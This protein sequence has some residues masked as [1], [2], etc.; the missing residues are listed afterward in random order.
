MSRGVTGRGGLEGVFESPHVKRIFTSDRALHD[1]L[2]SLPCYARA[3]LPVLILGEPGTGKE[4][5][6]EALWALSPR[7]EQPFVRL[8][9]ANLGGNLAGSELFGHLKGAFTG[10]ERGRAGKFK[11]AHRGTLFLDEVGDLPLSVQPRLLRVLERGEIEPLGSDS[12]LKV[13]VRLLAATNQ[14]LPQLIVQGKFRQDVFD[15]LAV[16]VIHLPPLRERGDD[17]L[18]LARHFLHE[19]AARYQRQVKDFSSAAERRLK[20]YHW[21]GNIRELRNVVTRAVLFSRGLLIQ[22]ADLYF[23]PTRSALPDQ[24]LLRPEGPAVRPSRAELLE[25]LW[26][27]GGN[28]SAA[29]RRLGVCTRTLYRWLKA[30][31]VDLGEI[32]TAA[33][34]S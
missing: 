4:L 13:D 33:P 20:G 3:D 29:A 7:A 19:E 21:P 27:E 1:L 16:L 22:D 31:T 30:Y 12:S 6:A 9:C 15:R 2:A 17:V 34:L 10:A 23:A 11:T 18:Y 25:L 24:A 14:N 32:R 5:I 26:E 8:N 28:I